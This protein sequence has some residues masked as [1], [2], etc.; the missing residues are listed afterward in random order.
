MSCSVDAG[1]DLTDRPVAL[2]ERGHPSHLVEGQ[3]WGSRAAC[4]LHSSD[5]RF[6][7]RSQAPRLH[8]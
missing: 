5:L 1:V 8:E 7:D 6:F 4:L 3:S 2:A